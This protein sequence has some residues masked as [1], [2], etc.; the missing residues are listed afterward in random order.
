M[1]ISLK[2]EHEQFIQAQIASG[3][4]TNPDEV[5]DLAFKVLEKLDTE[6]IQW[7]EQTRQKV[8]VGL[9]Q[10]ERGEVIDSEVVIDRLREKLRKAREAKE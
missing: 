9:A 8:E 7:L 2:P 5:I 3:R 10:I 1:N 6:Y 4:F